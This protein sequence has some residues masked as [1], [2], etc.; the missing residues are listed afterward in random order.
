MKDTPTSGPISAS[1]THHERE[2]ISSRHSFLRSHLHALGEGKE[3]LLEIRWQV[4]AST[5][6]RQRREGVKGAFRDNT[7]AAQQHEAIAD[8]SR[9]GDLVYRQAERAV[10]RKVLAQRR[11]GF[12]ALAQVEAFE[13]LVDQKYQLRRQQPDGQQGAFAH[14]LGE[15]ADRHAHQPR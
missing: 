3:D 9:V 11:R 7:A 13:W 1:I 12:T 10:R 4:V 5:L 14:S 6:A 15:G 8:L 2:L